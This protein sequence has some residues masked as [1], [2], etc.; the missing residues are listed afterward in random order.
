MYGVPSRSNPPPY[1]HRTSSTG[2]S[3]TYG[4]AMG[5]ANSS[6]APRTVKPTTYSSSYVSQSRRNMRR[7]LPDGPGPLPDR[8]NFRKTTGENLRYVSP[9]SK[10][11]IID[12]RHSTSYSS[13]LYGQQKTSSSERKI[14]NDSGYGSSS[15]VRYNS[16]S[17][18]KSALAGRRSKSLSNLGMRDLSISESP[19][20]SHSFPT[21]TIPSYNPRNDYSSGMQS[22]TKTVENVAQLDEN[23]NYQLPSTSSRYSSKAEDSRQHSST[24]R[25]STNYPSSNSPYSKKGKMIDYSCDNRKE[26]IT[27]DTESLR[28][29]S[30]GST[31]SSSPSTVRT[32]RLLHLQLLV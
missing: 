32:A 16:I 22:K 11:K 19:Q 17:N 10:S 18:G 25:Y 24:N 2:T 23:A 4:G 21:R 27:A 31:S 1:E 15:S 3:R 28:R 26:V 30:K 9:Q 14:S 7:Q 12:E 5:L 13:S 29:S 8:Y 6:V 20:N